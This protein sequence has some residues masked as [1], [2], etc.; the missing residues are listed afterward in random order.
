MQLA[1]EEGI[2]YF[3]G[4]NGAGKTALLEAVSVLARGRSFRSSQLTD[5]VASGQDAFTVR[6][7]VLDEHRGEQ[8]VAVMR[9]IKGRSQLKLNGEPGK[10]L[11]EVARILPVQIL[12]PSLSDLVFGSPAERRRWLDWGL[13]H[14]KPSYLGTLREYLQV[15]KQRNAALKSFDRGDLGQ[16]GIDVWTEKLVVIAEQVDNQRRIYMDDAAPEVLEVLETLSPK[17]D[18]RVSYRRGWSESESLEK[19]LRDSRA[20]DVKLG[21]TSAGPHR[22]DIELGVGVDL[23]GRASAV[24][25]R[26][27]GK[28]LAS[29]MVLG[30]ARLLMKVSRRNSVFLIDDLG[31]EMDEKHGA[32]LFRLLSEMDSQILATSTYPP[33]ESRSTNLTANNNTAPVAMFHVEHGRIAAKHPGAEPRYPEAT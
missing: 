4:E 31:A 2:N 10:S 24:L 25:S 12:L 18:V 29:A 27:Q 19:V 28:L 6:A 33:G 22:S 9:S 3:W 16:R 11:S 8:T 7:S 17:L 23:K 26:G 32:A 30:Q 20:R 15:L 14:V 21:A 1:L 13:F 5:L